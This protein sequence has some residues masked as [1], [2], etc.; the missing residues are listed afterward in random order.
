MVTDHIHDD[1]FYEVCPLWKPESIVPC[2][3]FARAS[4]IFP[5]ID[6]FLKTCYSTVERW[7]LQEGK[8]VP[9][10]SLFDHKSLATQKHMAKWNREAAPSRV[11]AVLSCFIWKY[12]M[13]PSRAAAGSSRPFILRR[14]MNMQQRTQSTLLDG[15][16][17]NIVCCAT[18]FAT[19]EMVIGLHKL[20]NILSEAI[21]KLDDDCEK[22]TKERKEFKVF[23][24]A[25]TS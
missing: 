1:R 8:H 3:D 19:A 9:R 12:F 22:S 16:I 23:W 20:T 5:P 17:G 6:P 21:A 18:A 15:A 7:W 25:Q 24:K 13:A 14:A 4:S 10:R 11:A 2:P